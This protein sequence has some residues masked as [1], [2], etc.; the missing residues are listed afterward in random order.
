M[1]KLAVALVLFAST[2]SA[3]HLEVVRLTGTRVTRG[4]VDAR[5]GEPIRLGLR[6]RRRALPSDAQVQ[7]LRVVPRLEH[8]LTAPPNEGDDTYSNAVLMGPDHGDWLGYDTLEYETHPLTDGAHVTIAG[9]ELEVR[10]A[11]APRRTGRAPTRTNDAA[12]TMWLAARVTLPDGRVLSSADATNTDRLGLSRRVQRLSFRTSDDF[13]G[14]LSSY[15]D[16]PYVFGSTPRQSE[17]Y[18]GIDCA[19]VLVGARRRESDRHLQYTSVNGISRLARDVSDVFRLRRDKTLRDGDGNLVSLRWGEDVREGDML[20][21]DYAEDEEGQLPRPWDHIGALL[22]DS[23]PDGRPDGILGG[24]DLL[25]HMGRRG[26]TD[27]A[28]WRHGP[29]RI[30]VWRWKR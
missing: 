6:L 25:R 16:V 10:G 3:Q 29:I 9:Q 28:L 19:D 4:A 17:R 13:L 27:E 18:V 11:P 5:V 7:W 30:R 22:S 23:G 20:A 1:T 24:D 12:G 21:I 2:A 26:L 14:W 15:F 8:T